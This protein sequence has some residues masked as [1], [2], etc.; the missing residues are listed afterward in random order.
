[1]RSQLPSIFTIIFLVIIAFLVLFLILIQPHLY[2]ER[3]ARYYILRDKII[4]QENLNSL[5]DSRWDMNTSQRLI[6]YLI[7]WKY[8]VSMHDKKSIKFFKKILNKTVSVLL[9]HGVYT[10]FLYNSTWIGV[11][12]ESNDIFELYINNSAPIVICYPVVKS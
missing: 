6:D 9:K 11:S 10:G 4:K 1:M 2:V 8:A 3:L 5:L 7:G 12:C